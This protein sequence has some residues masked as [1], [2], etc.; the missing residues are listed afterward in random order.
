MK[1][2]GYSI[3]ELLIVVALIGIVVSI[4]AGYS[5]KNSHRWSLRDDARQLS[6][7]F[8]QAKQQA[9][10]ENRLMQIQLNNSGFRIAYFDRQTQRWV[11]L[12]DYYFGS[13]TAWQKDPADYDDF[14]IAPSGI[15]LKSDNFSLAG[16]QVITLSA[17]ADAAESKKDKI[18]LTIFPYGGINVKREFK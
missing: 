6:A 8:H 12:K 9:A 14:V 3:I 18:I 5:L 15:I 4:V 2:K 7:S 11:N 1:R 17:P 13:K 10:K 16:M